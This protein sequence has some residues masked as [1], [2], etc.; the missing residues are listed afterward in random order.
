[1]ATKFRIWHD[2]NVAVVDSADICNDLIIRIKT[3]TK[4]N[5]FIILEW[6]AKNVS[7]LGARSV[8]ELQSLPQPLPLWYYT[9]LWENVSIDISRN[10]CKTVVSWKLRIE[11]DLDMFTCTL[12]WDC[13]A[14]DSPPRGWGCGCGLPLWSYQFH[15]Y[16]YETYIDLVHRLYD[17]CFICH[18]RTS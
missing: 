4:I 15:M 8:Y 5:L 1:M 13:M 16:S 2:S 10:L 3:I 17:I 18:T 14:S 11:N 6:R 9:P 12:Q 7:K